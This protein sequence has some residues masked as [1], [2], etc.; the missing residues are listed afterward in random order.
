MVYYKGLFKIQE[1]KI[2]ATDAIPDMN[3]DTP[4][5]KY[6]HLIRFND[7]KMKYVSSKRLIFLDK[8]GEINMFVRKGS[9]IKSTKYIE[10]E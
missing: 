5:F 8:W 6:R 2:L 3:F 7:G 4:H 10:R 9:N 1:V